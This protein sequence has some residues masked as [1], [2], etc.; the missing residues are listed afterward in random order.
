VL[1]ILLFEILNPV[2]LDKNHSLAQFIFHLSLSF[3]CSLSLHFFHRRQLTPQSI[4]RGE[5]V[6]LFIAL[7]LFPL[8]FPFD[9]IF[10]FF[11]FGLWVFNFFLD[12]LSF[13]ANFKA[14][15]NLDM[16]FSTNLLFYN[17]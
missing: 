4:D 15:L 5:F 12:S 11:F 1:S 14:F 13:S 9:L 2:P 17:N 7:F 3:S 6:S 10:S 16:I 8:S